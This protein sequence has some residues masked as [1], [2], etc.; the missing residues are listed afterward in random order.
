LY[1]MAAGAAGIVFLSNISSK[2][3]AG[4]FFG[5]LFNLY[6]LF[7][8]TIGDVAS[9]LRLYALGLATVAI[10]YVVNLMAG[11]VLGAPVLG[12]IFMLAVLIGG[13]T[14]NLLVN[15]L[16]AFVHPLR[17]QYV[18]FFGKFYEDGGEPF[19]PLAWETRKTVVD[20]E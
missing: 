18:E 12:I 16:G 1:V 15:F 4:K 7:G 17:L 13:H 8:G 14:F 11:M 2:S 3:I 20:E 6:G 9:Y 5:G 10:G 19:V